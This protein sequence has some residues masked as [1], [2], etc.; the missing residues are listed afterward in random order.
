MRD[1][2]PTP[3]TAALA[4]TA[5]LAATVLVPLPTPTVRLV[6]VLRAVAPI[7]RGPTFAQTTQT[8]TNDDTQ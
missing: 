1:S 4:A 7:A 5:L 8:M 3:S 6:E 2:R